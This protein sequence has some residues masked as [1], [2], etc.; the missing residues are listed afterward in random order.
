ME[1][2]NL[3]KNSNFLSYKSFGSILFMTLY[4]IIDS[5]YSD[6]NYIIININRNNFLNFIRV[7]KNLHIYQFNVLLDIWVVDLLLFNNEVDNNDRFELNFLFLSKIFG[8][9]L[10]VKF[11]V[12]ENVSLNSISEIFQNATWL[13]REV[14][15]FFG[16]NFL[17]QKD[18][19]RLLLD[20]GFKGNPMRK[21]FPLKGLVE[22]R[23]DYEER[24]I[25]FDKL[26]SKQP[27]ILF[28]FKNPWKN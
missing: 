20:Y 5:I 21:D 1:L 14:W 6:D 2:I 8:K 22:V 24:R 10:L 17:G 4:N 25:V 13:E 19:R 11:K 3:K 16:L 27:F 28:D 12:R 23:F 26:E 18:L 15:D 7:I 9:R